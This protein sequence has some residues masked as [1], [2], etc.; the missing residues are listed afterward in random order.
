MDREILTNTV[1]FGDLRNAKRPL[2]SG[3]VQAFWLVPPDEPDCLLCS[4][5]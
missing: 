2:F 5:F 1:A 3:A 4:C